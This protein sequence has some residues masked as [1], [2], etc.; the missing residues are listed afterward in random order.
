MFLLLGC[1]SVWVALVVLRRRGAPSVA[2]RPGAARRGGG[3]GANPLAARDRAPR[4]LRAQ[5]RAARAAALG[6]RPAVGTAARAAAAAQLRAARGRGGAASRDGAPR[7]SRRRAA[8]RRPALLCGRSARLS[9]TDSAAA[10]KAARCFGPK[11]F[12]EAPDVFA[13]RIFTKQA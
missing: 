10:A 4:A 11:S 1:N 13:G 3:A 8:P 9:E 5:S 6:E 2:V 12:F 7:G